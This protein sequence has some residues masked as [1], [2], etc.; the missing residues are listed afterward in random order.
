MTPAGSRREAA[1]RSAGQDQAAAPGVTD[2]DLIRAAALDCPDVAAISAGAFGQVASYLPGRIVPGVRVDDVRVE[3]HVVARYGPPLR[4]VA[5][6]IGDAVAP[7][8][9]GRPLRVVIDDILLPG[10]TLT[11]PDPGPPEAPLPPGDQPA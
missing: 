9:A 11:D 7:L 10:E 5:D 2:A 4:E 1:D 8:L 6:Q 3:V